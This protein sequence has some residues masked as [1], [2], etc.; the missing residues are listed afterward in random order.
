M[1]STVCCLAI[2]AV[3]EKQFDVALRLLAYLEQ[4][5]VGKCEELMTSLGDPAGDMRSAVSTSLS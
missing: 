2:T 4:F 3:S 5:G 1:S